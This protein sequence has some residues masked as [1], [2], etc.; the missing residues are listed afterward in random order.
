MRERPTKN[1]KP[2]G[3]GKDKENE[4]FKKKSSGKPF[5]KHDKKDDDARPF[6]KKSTFDNKDS[7]GS[8]ERQDNKK[9]FGDKGKKPFRRDNET[10]DRRSV[11]KPYRDNEKRPYKKRGTSDSKPIEQG[12]EEKKVYGKNERRPYKRDDSK[13]DEQRRT[14]YRNDDSRAFNRGEEGV[15]KPYRKSFD[16]DQG[17]DFEHSDKVERNVER[18]FAGRSDH[19]FSDDRKS[20]RRRRVSENK[21]SKNTEEGLIRL[22]RFISNGGYCSRRKADELIGAGAVRV[23][24][25]I[26]TE[27]GFKVNPGDK[28]EIGGVIIQTEAFQYVLLNKPKDYIT[29]SK[30]PQNRKTVMELIDGACKESIYP[31][32]RLDRNTTG[33]LL[34]TNDGIMAKKL[35]HPSS[36]IKKVYQATLDKN[37]KSTDMKEIGQG[38]E[39]DDGFVEIDMISYVEGENKNVVGIEIHSGKY[40]VIKRIFEKFGYQVIKLDRTLLGPLTKKNLPRG[41]W[42]FLTDAEINILKRI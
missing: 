28:V 41:F 32:G 4:R 23:N 13:H 35:M 11:G 12:S 10:T 6:R 2:S 9:S 37:L 18:K 38:V 25:K 24:G 29:T 42:R 5:I 7:K 19:S 36:R 14:F 26:V 27:M 1:D 3:R 33:L 16:S 30:D 40:H 21:E 20:G 15:S 34:F 39:L 31:V 22:N 17:R 8:D